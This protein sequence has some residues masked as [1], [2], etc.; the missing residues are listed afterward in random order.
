MSMQI[1]PCQIRVV[2]PNSRRFFGW[3]TE[4]DCHFNVERGLQTNT[5]WAAEMA[6]PAVK[7]P[8]EFSPATL[9][10][11]QFAAGG[12]AGDSKILKIVF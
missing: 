4:L 9:A 1:S 11:M 7:A 3:T 10:A 2:C 5:H 8:K 12:C 6:T